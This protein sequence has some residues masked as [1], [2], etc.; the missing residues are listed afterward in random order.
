M[1]QMNTPLNDVPL[2]PVRAT[3]LMDIGGFSTN[4][5]GDPIQGR[6]VNDILKYFADKEDGNYVLSK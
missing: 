3:E 4:V 6:R 2:D 1:E 5:F